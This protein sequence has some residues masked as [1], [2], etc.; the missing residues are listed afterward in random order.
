MFSEALHSFSDSVFMELISKMYLY[1]LL[2]C[3]YN[4]AWSIGL[5]SL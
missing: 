4:S 1:I 2:L 3:G 5:S